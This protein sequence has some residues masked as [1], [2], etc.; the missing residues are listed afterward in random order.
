MAIESAYV[1][2]LDIGVGSIGWSMIGCDGD[3]VPCTLRR[4]GSHIFECG[5]EGSEADRALGREVSRSAPRR[6]ARL[7]R[8]QIWRRAR[9]KRKLLMALI[10]HGLLPAPRTALQRPLDIDAYLKEVDAEVRS[11]WA[12]GGHADQ[13]RWPYLLRCAAAQRPVQA[14]DLGRALYHLAQRRGFL[15]N[16]RADAQARED[17]DRSAVKAAIG[18]LQQRI[19]AHLPPTLGAYLASLD[20][21]EQRIR[22]RWTSRAM[23]LAEFERLWSVQRE[24]LGLSD[25]ARTE[26]HRAIFW[27]RPLRAQK[28]LVGR[29]SLLPD[30]RRVPVACRLYQRFRVLQ[31]VNNIEVSVD[32]EPPRRLTS[33]ERAALVET[34]SRRGDLTFRDAKRAAGLP[35]TAR[36]NLEEGGERRIVG[37]RTDARL[38]AVIGDRFDSFSEADRDRMVEDLRTFRSAEALRRMAARPLPPPGTGR[39][40]VRRGE[41][42][43]ALWGWGLSEEQAAQFAEITLEEGYANLSIAAI[44]RLLPRL[45]AGEPYGS[46]RRAEFPESFRAGTA[47]EA[48]P[49]VFSHE[50]ARVIGALR[51]PT[52]ARALTEVRKLVNAIIREHGKPRLIR[53]ELS[54]DLKNPRSVRER[55]TRQNRQREKERAVAAERI[56][57]EARI[58]NPSRADIE[59]VLLADECGWQCPY[60]GRQIDWSTLLGPHPQFDVEHIWPRSRCLDDSFVNKTLC[61]HE[62]NRARKRGHTPFEAYGRDPRRWAEIIARVQRFKGDFRTRRE[63][64]RRFLAEEIDA[65]FRERHLSDTRFIARVA[66][67]YLGLLYGG[68]VE[69]NPDG[70]PGTRRVEVCSGGLT[71]WLRSGW[72][73]AGLL[74]DRPEKNRADHRHHAIDAVIV[75]LSDPRAVQVLARAAERADALGKVRAFEAI[76]EPW[77]GFREQVASAVGRV[78]VSHRQSR[79]VSGALHDQSIYTGPIHGSAR[80]SKELHKL[81]PAE[82]RDGKIVDKR[83]LAAIRAKLQELGRPEPTQRDITQI[84]TDP[85]NAPLVKGHDG[86]MVRLRRVRVRADA[87]TP[88]GRGASARH[89]QTSSNHHT[90]I[91]AEL[92]NAGRTRRW[93]DEPVTLLEAYRRQAAREPIVN[94]DL[95]PGKRF[96]FSLAAGEYLQMVAPDGS[97]VAVYRVTSVSKGDIALRLHFDARTEEELK[98]SK[99]RVRVSG[100]RLRKLGARKVLVTYLGEARRAGG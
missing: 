6:T 45:E 51:N 96:L 100:D 92:D 12:V 69:G 80:I 86:R 98:K 71:A 7:M 40:W 74:G 99:A 22:D 18:E 23:Y 79:R 62:E 75:A 94:R 81:S 89:V 10:R 67:D 17:E 36:F 53:V 25:E 33:E 59:K 78:V 68:R 16:R 49:P 32:G 30:E 42:V 19:D 13:Q 85:A 76:D 91:Y 88:I 15:S 5:T 20:P 61:F 26:I 95:G 87:G 2:G 38:R 90:V 44:E 57:R 82:I 60:T 24:H 52:V 21:D 4:V 48:L 47:L 50:A 58:A 29:C 73:L 11:R 14:H 35:A 9:R 97:G 72:G 55:I 63:K 46:A 84:F 43:E 34:L 8:R 1:L 28:G 66:A 41:V 70:G 37:H 3:G 27:Q 39:R 65:D 83:A 64:L 93:V 56:I 77:P 54:R 31:T